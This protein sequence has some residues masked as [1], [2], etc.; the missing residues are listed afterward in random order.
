MPVGSMLADSQASAAD[1]A[2][3][4]HRLA[5][6]YRAERGAELIERLVEGRDERRAE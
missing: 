5:E 4:I 6:R 1:D 2:G 3:A